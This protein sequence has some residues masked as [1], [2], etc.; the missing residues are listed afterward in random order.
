MDV[1]VKQGASEMVVISDV[2]SIGTNNGRQRM[3]ICM[4]ED[5]EGRENDYSII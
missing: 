1:R 2:E 4:R 3:A 5:I